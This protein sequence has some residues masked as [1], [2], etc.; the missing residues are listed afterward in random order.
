MQTGDGFA[1]KVIVSKGPVRRDDLDECEG[2]R[3]HAEEQVRHGKIDD[4]HVPRR[5]HG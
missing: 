4:E 3:D 1:E 2:H 5:P